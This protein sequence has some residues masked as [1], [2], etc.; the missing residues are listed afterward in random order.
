MDSEYVEYLFDKVTRG[1]ALIAEKK[2]AIPG[3]E[4]KELV[5]MAMLHGQL[6]RFLFVAYWTRLKPFL[7]SQQMS[8]E[9]LLLAYRTPQMIFEFVRHIESAAAQGFATPA[10]EMGSPSSSAPAG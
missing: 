5:M 8:A 7:K 2:L 6:D 9:E 3:P 1:L 4:L 10:E